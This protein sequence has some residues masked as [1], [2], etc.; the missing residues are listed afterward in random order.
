VLLI[1]EEVT[2]N[3]SYCCQGAGQWLV[4]EV[5]RGLEK[6]WMVGWTTWSW[7]PGYEHHVFFSGHS[8]L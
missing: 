3:F 5:S 2:V 1:K 7:N 4:L 6:G 8:S